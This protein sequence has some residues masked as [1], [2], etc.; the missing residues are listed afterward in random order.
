MKIIKE[1]AEKMNA[2]VNAPATVAKSTEAKTIVSQDEYTTLDSLSKEAN[3]AKAYT[4]IRGAAVDAVINLLK[5]KSS[6]PLFDFRLDDAG[7]GDY[8]LKYPEYT[9]DI[10][11]KICMKI[12]DREV[13]A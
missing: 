2:K 10:I 9:L 1:E 4:E 8:V 6:S 5:N 7:N 3:R 12:M 11:T 13:T